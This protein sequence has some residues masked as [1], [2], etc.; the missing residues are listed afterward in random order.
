MKLNRLTRLYVLKNKRHFFIKRCIFFL[1]NLF[2]PQMFLFL[3]FLSIFYP[4]RHTALCWQFDNCTFHDFAQIKTV[5]FSGDVLKDWS[6]ILCVWIA[7]YA[8][9]RLVFPQ[10]IS[11]IV[12]SLFI[13]FEI[14]LG[15][16]N[17]YM[18]VNYF[19]NLEPS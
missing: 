6:S 13:I 1:K 18:V 5:L 4:L 14:L 10:K 16:A 11:N 19:W 3:A 2:P 7:F 9:L 17:F 8:L 12:L 15:L